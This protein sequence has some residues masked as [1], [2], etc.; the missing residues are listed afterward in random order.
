MSR[1]VQEVNTRLSSF[2]AVLAVVVVLPSP[3][4]AQAPGVRA[5]ISVDPDQFFVGG[6]YETGPL[7]DRLHFKPNIEVGFGD[8]ITHVG[9]NFEFVYKILTR[10]GWTLYAGGGPAINF[11]S[12]DNDDRGDDDTE[13]EGGLN[14][15]FGAEARNGLF[16]E[17]KVGAIDS[18]D[19]KF[20][21]GWTFR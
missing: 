1:V 14:F 11:Y 21:V 7:V 8:D 4:A 17:L 5:G 6:H 20:G 19:L 10:Q 18:P 3:A 2:L 15:L 13:T 16:F 9:V 12:F